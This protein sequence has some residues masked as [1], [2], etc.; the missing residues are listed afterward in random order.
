[1]GRRLVDTPEG[2]R[3][4][5]GKCR[6]FVCGFHGWTYDLEGRNTW[7][8]EREDWPTGLTEEKT[9]LRNVQVDTW[10]GWIWINMDP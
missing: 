2:K 7:A 9:R 1:R 8:A 4:A 5:K 3:E 6:T 10:G